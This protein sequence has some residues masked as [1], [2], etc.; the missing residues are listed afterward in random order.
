MELT[1]YRPFRA[2]RPSKPFLSQ[3]FGNGLWDFFNGEDLYT[4]P[5]FNP[6]IDV[7]E[8]DKDF[9]MKAE[10]PGMD[11]GDIKL[12][13]TDGLI[14][15]KGERKKEDKVEKDGYC[16]QESRYGSFERSFRLP[17]HVDAEKITAELKKGVL[18]ITIP[19]NEE[20]EPKKIEIHTE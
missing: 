8:T 13:V 19:K 5:R 9:K 10:L 2:V 14:T 18:D 6:S 16:W 7:E 15:L 1:H 17:E 4:T 12:E 20:T 11:E 3:F